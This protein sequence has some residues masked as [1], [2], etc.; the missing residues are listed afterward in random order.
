MSVPRGRVCFKKGVVDSKNLYLGSGSG[1]SRSTPLILSKNERSR[2]R[3]MEVLSKM[4]TTPRPVLFTW[5]RDGEGSAMDVLLSKRF[6]KG[7][8][9]IFPKTGSG[10]GLKRLIMSEVL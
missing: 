2:G 6:L 5:V 1:F 4:V 3:S 10:S 9:K 7:V 8:L